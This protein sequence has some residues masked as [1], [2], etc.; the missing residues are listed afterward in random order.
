MVS[1]FPSHDSQ[2]NALLRVRMLSKQ[3][4]RGGRWQKCVLEAVREVDL[5]ICAGQTLAL[6]GASGS[7]KSTVAR[8]V[9]RLER[10]DSGQI[11]FDGTEIAGF[12]A[13]VLL[14]IRSNIQMIFQDAVT[15]M[16][17]RFTAA[18]AIEEPLRI[19]GRSGSERRDVAE[20][21]IQEVALSPEW[22]T[23]PVME[24]S[25]GQRQRLAI[26]RA[27]TLRPKLLVLDEALSGLDLSTQ[28]QIAN[29]LL[30]LQEMH[31]L[32]YLLISHDLTLVARMADALA[33]MAEGR[34]VETGAT[35]QI[36][37]DAKHA[38]TKRLLASARTAKSTFASA[39]GAS[40]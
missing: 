26:A 37:A 15:S 13:R 10:P 34:I 8:C 29:L 35:Q 16:N 9:T 14:P 20:A 25:G 4:V 2:S 36:I 39:A 33:V 19:Q 40:A 30:D 23:R 7:G 27:L 12:G 32:T 6:V 38:E 1:N 3:Y 22:L 21:L 17:P 28:A 31:S 11:W 18:E 5:D 24:F